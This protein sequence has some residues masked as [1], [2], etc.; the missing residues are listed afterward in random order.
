MRTVELRKS[1]FL[2]VS[3]CVITVLALLGFAWGSVVFE[4][5]ISLLLLVS[6]AIISPRYLKSR[7]RSGMVFF[8]VGTTIL[9]LLSDYLAVAPAPIGTEFL[10]FIRPFIGL[11]AFGVLLLY[12][13]VSGLQSVFMAGKRLHYLKSTGLALLSIVIFICGVKLGYDLRLHAFATLGKRFQ[14]LITA[15]KNYERDR[16][17]PP[18]EL[19]LLEPKYIEKL[20]TSTGMA[21]YSQYEYE[22]FKDGDSPWEIS[23]PCSSG[24]LNWDVFFY[25]PSQKYPLQTYGG[26][27]E[28]IDDWAYVH[29]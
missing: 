24:M 15:I 16:G 10:L 14:P 23:I 4:L 6:L 25:W 27:V 12:F 18:S 8:C 19:K 1:S 13:I 9:M 2:K 28:R 7:L 17:A 5:S 3:V 26:I 22:V 20:P 21:A 29:E 11:G